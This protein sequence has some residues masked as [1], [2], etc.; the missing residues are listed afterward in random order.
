[1][2]SASRKSE[3]WMV[4]ETCPKGPV[5]TLILV[6]IGAPTSDRRQGGS[7]GRRQVQHVATQI[8]KAGGRDLA[9]R[10]RARRPPEGTSA[11][12]AQGQDCAD[13]G[14]HKPQPCGRGRDRPRLKGERHN[15]PRRKK[16]PRALLTGLPGATYWEV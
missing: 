4:L 7:H 15:A 2:F 9:T 16:G 10:D 6:S 11:G 3:R 8:L 12:Q 5:Q 14:R 13:R 1:G